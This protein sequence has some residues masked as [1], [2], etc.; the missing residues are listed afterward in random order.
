MSEETGPLKWQDR[1]GNEHILS[2]NEVI[3]LVRRRDG[4]VFVENTGPGWFDAS[5]V[6]VARWENEAW[7]IRYLPE[8]PGTSYDIRPVAGGFVA[9]Y[10]RGGVT[11]YDDEGRVGA[12]RCARP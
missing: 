4:F 10:S 9:A 6:G 5:R 1:D 7:A 11:I 2:E 12:A 8:P 3:G